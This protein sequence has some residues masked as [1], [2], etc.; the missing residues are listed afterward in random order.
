M[1]K[2]FKKLISL[3]S[4]ILMLFPEL[5]PFVGIMKVD[6]ALYEGPTVI[7]NIDLNF[8]DHQSQDI[9]LGEGE[10]F[11]SCSSESPRIASTTISADN[12]VCTITALSYGI[13]SVYLN[14]YAG[15]SYEKTIF[16]NVDNNTFLNSF[17]DSIPNEMTMTYPEYQKYIQNYSL[18]SNNPNDVNV[19]FEE[20]SFENGTFITTAE[21]TDKNYYYFN[22]DGQVHYYENEDDATISKE[23]RFNIIGTML[24]GDLVHASLSYLSKIDFVTNTEVNYDNLIFVSSDNNIFTVD[25]KGYV[26]GVSL[27]NG[28]VYVYD[29]ESDVY[30]K[31]EVNVQAGFNNN[32]DFSAITSYFNNQTFDVNI[33]TSTI[34]KKAIKYTE[35]GTYTIDP[36]SYFTALYNE[37]F[38]PIY[39]SNMPYFN[40]LSCT[41]NVCSGSGSYYYGSSGSIDITNATFNFNGIKLL[42]TYL[43]ADPSSSFDLNIIKLGASADSEISFTYDSDYLTENANG[44][45]S[46]LKTGVTEVTASDGTYQSTAKMFISPTYTDIAPITNYFNN[47]SSITLTYPVTV[48]NDLNFL[49]KA[50]KNYLT[51]NTPESNGYKNLYEYDVKC[52][53]TNMCQIKKNEYY[54]AEHLYPSGFYLSSFNSK[55]IRINYSLAEATELTAAVNE[56]NNIDSK[57]NIAFED[58]EKAYYSCDASDT[59]FNEKII[60]AAELQF[61]SSMLSLSDFVTIEQIPDIYYT[62]EGKVQLSLYGEVLYSKPVVITYNKIHTLSHLLERTEEYKINNY[63]EK[64]V[65]MSTT[66]NNYSLTTNDITITLVRDK[67]YNIAYHND[68]EHEIT[69]N[70]MIDQKEKVKITGL[71]FGSNFPGKNME[72]GDEEVLYY[73]VYP[74]NANYGTVEFVSADPT[75]ISVNN[76]TR[77]ITALKKGYTTIY[78]KINGKVQKHSGYLSCVDTTYEDILNDMLEANGPSNVTITYYDLLN[79]DLISAITNEV[80]NQI[81]NNLNRPLSSTVEVEEIGTT[82]TYKYRLVYSEY[83]YGSSESSFSYSQYKNITYDKKGISTTDNEYKIDINEIVDTKLSFSEADNINLNIRIEDP[84]IVSYSNSGIL[85]GL[86]TGKTYISIYDKFDKY[87]NDIYVTVDGDTLYTNIIDELND[88]DTVILPSS[89]IA[90]TY[91]SYNQIFDTV[92]LR[93]V[94]KYDLFNTHTTICNNVNSTCTLSLNYELNG[95]EEE[96]SKTYAFLIQGLTI[97]NNDIELAT[98][99]SYTLE[100]TSIPNTDPVTITSL[101]PETCSIVDDEVLALQRGGCYVK[102]KNSTDFDVLKVAIDKDDIIAEYQDLLD[103]LPNEITLKIEEYNGDIGM[104]DYSY[105]AAYSMLFKLAIVDLLDLNESEITNFYPSFFD[106]NEDDGTMPVSL[107]PNLSYHDEISGEYYGVNISPVEKAEPI[108]ILYDNDFIADQEEVDAIVATLPKEYRLSIDQIIKYRLLGGQ[109]IDYTDFSNILDAYPDYELQYDMAGAGGS[110]AMVGQNYAYTVLKDGYVVA[111]GSVDVYM[112]FED[113]NTTVMTQEE[114]IEYLKGLVTDEYISVQNEISNLTTLAV[115]MDISEP[116]ELLEDSIYG[117]GD[118]TPEVTVTYIR[119]SADPTVDTYDIRVEDIAFRLTVGKKIAQGATY[120]A[121]YLIGDLTGDNV[122]STTDLVKLRRHLAGIESVTGN[123]L[124][125]ADINRDNNVTTTDLVKLRRHLAGIESIA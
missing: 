67:I 40:S 30:Y 25:N 106:L 61:N 16:V 3:I 80:S 7:E 62:M 114:Y 9:T 65:D 4:I 103:S 48:F 50:V 105:M 121:S 102:I 34:A 63:K 60:E 101:T 75:I 17:L 12:K 120:D 71:S 49:S 58:I 1:K 38:T 24:Y 5:F 92:L 18:N 8:T 122:I 59:C 74:E 111:F 6:A 117:L 19:Y 29:K 36:A 125:A 91:G 81:N 89:A 73:S 79:F 32:P 10:T 124:K 118:T 70:F 82:G 57:I 113:E 42:E 11:S 99:E 96:F 108:K 90:N 109:M 54:D 112:Y 119:N 69:Y 22:N 93:K 100:Y 26:K 78:P 43:I 88:I 72:I 44:T 2:T 20:N 35:G 52:I 95:Q 76:T 21:V 64:I 33:S 66:L 68:N 97:E 83:I 41:N 94:D 14:I 47:L 31:L 27:G 104:E 107:Y 23:V 46:A 37:H 13:S 56:L 51:E 77:T 115:R 84:S 55:I 116:T 45:F 39:G 53:N 28:Y 15:G 85:K 87:Y 86:K 98:G 123:K 110:M